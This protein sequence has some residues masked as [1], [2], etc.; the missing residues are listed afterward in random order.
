MTPRTV[1]Y[2]LASLIQA[3]ANCERSGNLEWYGKHR[4]T[5]ER[6]VKDFMPSGSGIDLGTQ[7]DF[8][9]STPTKL[10]FQTG[11]HHMN[12]GGMYD[13]WTDHTVTVRPTFTGLDLRV[14]GS[15]RHDIKDYL[16]EVFDSAL[17]NL[18]PEN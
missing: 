2:A 11:F 6:I 1:A 8:E 18:I 3:R 5:A 10:V 9:R 13:G 16:A 15:N 14:S 12:D 7:L 17:S 4:A